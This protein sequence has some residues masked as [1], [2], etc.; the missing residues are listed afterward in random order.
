M[1][2]YQNLAPYFTQCIRLILALI[3]YKMLFL[4]VKDLGAKTTISF[5]LLY[6]LLKLIS[7]KSKNG[8]EFP[9]EGFIRRQQRESPHIF[10]VETTEVGLITFFFLNSRLI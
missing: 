5:I 9:S 10:E 3:T 4:R 7:Q 6:Y 1:V 2:Q 8:T